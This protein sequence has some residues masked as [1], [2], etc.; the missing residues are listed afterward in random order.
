M[1]NVRVKFFA[2]AHDLAGRSEAILTL[3][4]SSST[5]NALDALMIQY[6]PLI[7]LKNYLRVAVNGEYVELG[8][9]LQD[10]DELAIIPPVS[11][12]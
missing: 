9:S 1:M 4:S 3:P 10:D 7:A 12:G 6:P 2:M 8:Y 11:G 5:H